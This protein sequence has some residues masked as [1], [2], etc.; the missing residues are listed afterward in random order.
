MDPTIRIHDAP[1]DPVHHTVDRVAE[2]LARGHQDG[3]RG[4]DHNGGFVMQP[5]NIV[6]NTDAI[7]LQM[8]LKRR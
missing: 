1:G 3:G 7:K 5:K 4:E 2:V 8:G 6:V